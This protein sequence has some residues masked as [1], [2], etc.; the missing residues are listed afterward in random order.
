MAR[1]RAAQKSTGVG[2]CLRGCRPATAK[3]RQKSTIH[4]AQPAQLAGVD[5]RIEGL[6]MELQGRR[7]EDGAIPQN[8]FTRGDVHH[9]RLGG[10]S[11]LLR[12]EV[13]DWEGHGVSSI[14]LRS[15]SRSWGDLRGR[16]RCH[17]FGLDWKFSPSGAL[18]HSGPEIFRG[19]Q[20]RSGALLMR[21]R[22]VRAKSSKASRRRFRFGDRR[23]KAPTH[24]KWDGFSSLRQGL[25]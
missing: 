21:R 4:D 16:R 12:L 15:C 7:P 22:D 23:E 13:R 1:P 8:I 9:R 19:V 2:P 11:R 18:S 14:G 5:R 20:A 25:R 17:E 6:G 3:A 10:G 24:R